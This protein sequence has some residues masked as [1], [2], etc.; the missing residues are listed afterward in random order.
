MKSERLLSTNIRFHIP[1][2]RDAF[3]HLMYQ[4][5]GYRCNT[6][7]DI[8]E[9]GKRR[10]DPALTASEKIQIAND[11]LYTTSSSSHPIIA[12]AA[13]LIGAL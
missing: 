12:D 1:Y 5:L 11:I 6:S 8:D 3:N 13:L 7:F 10:T 4:D 9:M 2:M